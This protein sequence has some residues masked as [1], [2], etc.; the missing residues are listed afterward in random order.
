[1][2]CLS[3][4]SDII[5]ISCVLEFINFVEEQILCNCDC[6]RSWFSVRPI[7]YSISINFILH[8][9]PTDRG[10]EANAQ[11][12]GVRRSVGPGRSAIKLSHGSHA[13]LSIYLL[14]RTLMAPLGGVGGAG[15]FGPAAI[16]CPFL[17]L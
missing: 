3:K 8:G 16:S 14:S 9:R 17:F 7:N 12:T 15:D 5:I 10:Q 2:I 1:M 13:I 6:C 4:L 11:G